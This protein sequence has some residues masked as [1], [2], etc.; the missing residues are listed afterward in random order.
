[1]FRKRLSWQ[2]EGA[3]AEI[4]RHNFR[5]VPIKTLVI[6]FT[7]PHK[8]LSSR[9]GFKKKEIKAV[10]NNFNPPQLWDFIHQNWE[11]YLA[12][13]I[14]D[15][16]LLPSEVAILSTGVDID[17]CAFKVEEYEELNVSA[18]VTAGVESNAMRIGVDKAGSMEREGKFEQ[19]GT[20]NTILLT[21][22]CLSESAMVRSLITV[23]E[24][25]TI[26]LQDMDIRSSYNPDVQATGTGTDHVIIV[27]GEG[28]AV[29]YCGGHCKMGELMARAVTSATKEAILKH[30][31]TRSG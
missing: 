3:V 29:S 19:I 17:H 22:A 9:E 21:N 31:N 23:T 28:P 15:L 10:C 14:V 11:L 20:I 27:S 26:A 12:E 1:M 16:K 13:I 30:G 25:K 2:F 8:A 5:D 18:F 4:V 7:H 24:A 6:S